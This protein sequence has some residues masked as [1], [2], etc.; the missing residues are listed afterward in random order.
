MLNN[1]CRIQQNVTG[2]STSAASNRRNWGKLTVF[3][4]IREGR[5]EEG[6]FAS[7]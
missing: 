4:K 2:L 6:F 5:N 7:I 3:E 1:S